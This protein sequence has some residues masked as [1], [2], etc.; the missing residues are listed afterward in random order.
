MNFRVTAIDAASAQALET[1]LAAHKGAAVTI[2]IS[3]EG[4]DVTAGL[5]MANAVQAHGQVTAVADGIAASAATLPLMAAAAVQANAGTLLMFHQPTA[6]AGGDAN[7]MQAAADALRAAGE[8]M[9]N[10]YANRGLSPQAV[11]ALMG[12][13]D[14]WFTAAQ[15][16]EAGLIDA[17]LAEPVSAE[18]SLAI[19]ARLGAP[20]PHPN[21]GPETR[22]AGLQAAWRNALQT[23]SPVPVGQ[24]ALQTRFVDQR[25]TRAQA[26]VEAI[27]IRAGSPAV[28]DNPA[29]PMR[30]MS[31]KD[32]EAEFKNGIRAAGVYPAGRDSFPGILSEAANRALGY[33]FS[34]VNEAWRM[35][36]RMIPVPDFRE[37]SLASL[38]AIETPPENIGE[39]GQIP[40]G[41]RADQHESTALYTT[42]LRFALSRRAIVN[43]DLMAF[44]QTPRALAAACARRIG[45]AMV[46]LFSSNLRD[47]NALFDADNTIAAGGVSSAN[48]DGARAKLALAEDPSGIPANHRLAYLLTPE[49]VLGRVR[50]V[51]ASEYEVTGVEATSDA[52][53]ANR[54][55][56]LIPAEN[57]IPDYRLDSEA[58]KPIIAVAEGALLCL[59]LTDHESPMLDEMI[60]DN[61]DGYA[62]K[63]VHDYRVA[64]PGRSGLVKIQTS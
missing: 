39:H 43:D 8:L 53:A 54:A 47:G 50:A 40:F 57:C 48:L 28:K 49:E 51:I 9:G 45:D 64:T 56:N 35:V 7:D 19:A 11:Q 4:G 52:T 32:I 23:G 55:R 60:L 33:E 34:E 13:G 30:G 17:V 25:P 2:I 63:L 6:A 38:G 24:A 18:G 41:N 1:H 12:N 22:A 59:H 21:G 5:R 58:N 20:A 26:A 16:H 29:N 62:W 42:A 14:S 10:V 3:S 44:T 46:A 61:R 15:A 31:L 27:L 36:C 37:V